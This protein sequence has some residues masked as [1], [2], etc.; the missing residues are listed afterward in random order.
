MT[1]VTV[2]HFKGGTYFEHGREVKTVALDGVTYF[3]GNHL[4]IEDWKVCSP[5]VEEPLY[6]RKIAVETAIVLTTESESLAV[7]AVADTIQDTGIAA[8]A[9]LK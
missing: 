5:V 9:D 2:G 8:I 6:R 7:F 3:L 4:L 1:P